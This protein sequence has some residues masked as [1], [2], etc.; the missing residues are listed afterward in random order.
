MPSPLPQYM[1]PKKNQKTQA[2]TSLPQLGSLCNLFS[3]YSMSAL[4]WT[5]GNVQRLQISHVTL[6]VLAT[7]PELSWKKSLISKLQQP[8]K[9]KTFLWA[10]V[11]SWVVEEEDCGNLSSHRVSWMTKTR[12]K[13]F[14]TS[15]E[16]LLQH[17]SLG[18]RKR[19]VPVT[20]VLYT[21]YPALF[22]PKHLSSLKHGVQLFIYS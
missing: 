12:K 10:H 5:L 2:N 11:L 18:N 3:S 20:N 9:A 21:P 14:D 17:E 15:P 16:C 22:P 4:L 19:R 7:P 6:N 8:G 13:C 1:Q